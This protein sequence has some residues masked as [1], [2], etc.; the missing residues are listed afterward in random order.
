MSAEIM[1]ICR[2]DI[3]GRL[4]GWWTSVPRY[5]IDWKGIFLKEVPLHS[6]TESF[7]VSG[8]G[9][10]TGIVWPGVGR[11]SFGAAMN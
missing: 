1:R 4:V 3:A 9:I 5:H 7:S 8:I 6:E 2:R 11:D 10:R